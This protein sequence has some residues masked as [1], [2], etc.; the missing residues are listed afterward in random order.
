MESDKAWIHKPES[1]IGD[2]T[3]SVVIVMGVLFL[4]ALVGAILYIKYHNG[5]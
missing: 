1:A 2:S 5:A 4:A 3:K